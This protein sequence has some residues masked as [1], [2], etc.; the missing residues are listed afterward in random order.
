MT[1][2]ESSVFPDDIFTKEQRNQ[3]AIILHIIGFL[4][5]VY[6]LALVCDKFFVPSVEEMARRVSRYSFL[7]FTFNFYLHFIIIYL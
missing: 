3:G 6:A 5:M 4:Y 7:Q 1:N 2:E